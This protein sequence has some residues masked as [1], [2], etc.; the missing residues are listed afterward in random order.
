MLLISRDSQP[1]GNYQAV[2]DLL[3]YVGK[4]GSP[5]QAGVDGLAIRPHS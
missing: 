4:R 2:A 5:L 1:D 3:V